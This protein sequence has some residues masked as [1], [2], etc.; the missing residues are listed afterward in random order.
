MPCQYV[1]VKAFYPLLLM[2]SH[3]FGVH[4]QPQRCGCRILLGILYSTLFP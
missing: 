2:V 1:I 4:F 3:K